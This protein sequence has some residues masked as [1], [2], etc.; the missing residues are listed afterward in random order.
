[1]SSLEIFKI[2]AP[3]VGLIIII[4]SILGIF[5]FSLLYFFGNSYYMLWKFLLSNP[6]L[7]RKQINKTCLEF[8]E[9]VVHHKL[10]I[11]VEARKYQI[12]K[13]IKKNNY[14]VENE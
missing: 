7:I 1:L 3:Q 8:K 5:G 10:D 9:Q 13:F 4:Y 14:G 12:E 2:I 11:D 6:D